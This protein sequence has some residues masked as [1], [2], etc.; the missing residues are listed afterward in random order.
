VTNSTD[1]TNG[2]L[3]K[4]VPF[5][6]DVETIPARMGEILL[7]GDVLKIRPVVVSTVA[8]FMI[9][10]FSFGA[11]TDECTRYEAVYEIIVGAPVD[12]QRHEPVTDLVE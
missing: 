4:P 8:V 5:S 6:A 10:L 3:R 2:E 9:D 1:L 7:K 11:R 12:R